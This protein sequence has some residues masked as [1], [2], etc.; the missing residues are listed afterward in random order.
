MNKIRIIDIA[1]TDQGAY[2]LL[3]TRVKKIDSD[4][5]FENVILCPEGLWQRKMINDG[6]KCITYNV[7]RELGIRGIWREIIELERILVENNPQ[8]VH[9]HNSKTGALARIA[10]KRVNKKYGKKIT[11]IHQVHGFFFYR[12]KGN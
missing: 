11:M 2:R 12:L 1:S 9:S 7:H 5:R 6:V 8:I 3:K 10:V 4:M